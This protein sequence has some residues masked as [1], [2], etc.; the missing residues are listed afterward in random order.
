MEKLRRIRTASYRLWCFVRV[1]VKLLVG[2]FM[3]AGRVG[4]VYEVSLPEDVRAFL[5]SLSRR[6]ATTPLA[7]QA[8]GA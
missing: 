6:P 5:A 4:S 7:P 8:S 1:K 3:L 2:F